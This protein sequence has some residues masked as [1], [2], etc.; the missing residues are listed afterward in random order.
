MVVENLT[1]AIECS[2]K[3]ILDSPLPHSHWGTGGYSPIPVSAIMALMMGVREKLDEKFDNS[4][5]CSGH[6][7]RDIVAETYR[8]EFQWFIFGRVKEDGDGR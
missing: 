3:K 2:L 4:A 7:C 6:P 8:D 5:K 1:E